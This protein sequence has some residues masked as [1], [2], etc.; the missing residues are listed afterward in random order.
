MI[1]KIKQ[2]SCSNDFI[3]QELNCV[4]KTFPDFTSVVFYCAMCFRTCVII[5]LHNSLTFTALS[6]F[7]SII[8]LQDMGGYGSPQLHLTYWEVHSSGL[9]IQRIL[10]WHMHF[11][12][13]LSDPRWSSIPRLDDPEELRKEFFQAEIAFKTK[14]V[15][16]LCL[17]IHWFFRRYIYS[18]ASIQIISNWTLAFESQLL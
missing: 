8:I 3:S 1:L 17:A 9:L 13:R 4:F 16:S 5:A 15:Q 10:T 11:K 6:N 2:I 12:E 18:S 14:I 7:L